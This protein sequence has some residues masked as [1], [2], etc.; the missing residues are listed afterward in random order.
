[1]VSGSVSRVAALKI[2]R[3]SVLGPVRDFYSLVVDEDVKKPTKQTRCYVRSSMQGRDSHD[4]AF[5]IDERK[6]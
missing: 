4:S 5:G 2:V 3:R 1:M 6:P